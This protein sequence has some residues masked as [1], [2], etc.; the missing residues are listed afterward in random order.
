[1]VPF[2]LFLGSRSPYKVTNPKKGA[3]TIR[4]LLGYQGTKSP[5]SGIPYPLLYSLLRTVSIRTSHP[6]ALLQAKH[7]CLG[8][9]G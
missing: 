1:M 5:E 2:T 4:W 6:E 7:R 3:L 8:F 9:K